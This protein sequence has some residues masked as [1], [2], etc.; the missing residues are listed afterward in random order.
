[1]Q[2]TLLALAIGMAVMPAHA[3][4]PTDPTVQELLARITA[5]E[6]RLAAVEGRPAATTEATEAVDQRLRVVERRQELQAEADAA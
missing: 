4:D 1:M 6:Q 2:R 5:L 3:A